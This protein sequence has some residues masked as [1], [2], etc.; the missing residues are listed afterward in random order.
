MIQ[1]FSRAYLLDNLIKIQAF[2][3]G[4]FRNNAVIRGDG[5]I[6]E[7]TVHHE[8]NQKGQHEIKRDT[9]IILIF[10]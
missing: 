6:D 3:I 5:H 10:G 1:L 9:D 4:I 7:N 2:F 8:Y